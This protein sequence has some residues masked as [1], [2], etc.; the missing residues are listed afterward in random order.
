VQKMF[1]FLHLLGLFYLLL[2][3]QCYVREKPPSVF[4]TP[5]VY[6]FCNMMMMIMMMMTMMIMASLDETCSEFLYNLL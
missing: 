4:V 2:V 6:I 3:W 1:K 5:S